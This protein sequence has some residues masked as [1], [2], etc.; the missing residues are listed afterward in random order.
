MYVILFSF[1]RKVPSDILLSK[2]KGTRA[3]FKY[4]ANASNVRCKSKPWRRYWSRHSRRT[5]SSPRLALACVPLD[6][7]LLLSFQSSLA[8][9]KFN[10]QVKNNQR[11]KR[12]MDTT[13]FV[14]KLV[15]NLPY[16]G[17]DFMC[18]EG[19]EQSSQVKNKT[20]RASTHEFPCKL[21]Q[22]ELQDNKR[23]RGCLWQYNSSRNQ[24]TM[25]RCA[26]CFDQV[27]GYAR[28]RRS[29]T[30]DPASNLSTGAQQRVIDQ[31]RLC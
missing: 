22:E 1:N 4:P 11:V 18:G 8:L 30:C 5:T 19:R 20:W 21:V 31:L 17:E 3:C 14:M 26:L 25:H 29:K 12:A 13:T 2:S 23:R 24:T 9:R 16:I 27:K 15:H 10:G 7:S 6:A 28:G